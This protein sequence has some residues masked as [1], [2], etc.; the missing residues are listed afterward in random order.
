MKAVLARLRKMCP[1]FIFFGLWAPNIVRGSYGQERPCSAPIN[2][3]LGS[4]DGQ[5][6]L[7][8]AALISAADQ[9]AAI[10]NSA[11]HKPLFA[12]DENA[13]LPINFVYSDQE[14]TTQTRLS[15]EA[16]LQQTRNEAAQLKKRIALLEG[17]FK[18]KQDSYEA[19]LSRFGSQ[20]DE[21]DLQIADL[22]HKRGPSEV[23][24]L[25][26]EMKR[27]GL[28]RQQT[29][30]ESR[31]AD[32]DAERENLKSLISGYNTLVQR[33]RDV[34]ESANADA[35]KEF[36]A[37]EYDENGADRKINVYE[38]SGRNDLVTVIAH[39]FGHA[40]GL[41]H[42]DNPNSLMSRSKD[43]IMHAAS[44]DEDGQVELSPDDL[45]DLRSL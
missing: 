21:Y 28:L 24:H 26:L 15:A 17:D 39:E 38:F 5:F 10:W 23:E 20:R 12:F 14:Q 9:A 7:N 8:R 33:E 34:I 32:L 25:V 37:G 4:V 1:L 43:E 13:E 18:N 35:G 16:S 27:R 3:R 36:L 22:N 11:A 31:A 40:L 6:G 2:Y 29:K 30:L 42:N 45:K 44:T 19:D 41:D